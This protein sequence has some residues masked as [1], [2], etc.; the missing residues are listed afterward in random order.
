MYMNFII[1]M[2]P[3]KRRKIKKIADLVNIDLIE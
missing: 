2:K 1:Y 3:L